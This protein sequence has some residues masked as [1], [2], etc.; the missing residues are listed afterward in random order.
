MTNST[1]EFTNDT[2]KVMN[3]SFATAMKT[4]TKVFEETARFWFDLATQNMD[5]FRNRF[6]R[7]A[8]DAVPFSKKNMDRV[9]RTFEDQA[10]RNAET[11]RQGIEVFQSQSPAEA[12]DHAMMFCRRSIET[13]RHACETFAKTNTEMFEAWTQMTQ[14]PIN[15]GGKAQTPKQPAAK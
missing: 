4:G 5:G 15:G 13:M 2:M 6:E 1:H 12:F 14:A 3:E 11:L 7:V 10:H 9:Q 8:D